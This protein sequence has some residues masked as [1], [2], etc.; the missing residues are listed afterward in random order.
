[1]AEEKKAGPRDLLTRIREVAKKETGIDLP[2]SLAEDLRSKL[3][4]LRLAPQDATKVVREVARRFQKAEVDA[5][6]S[7]GIIAAQSI[8]E[9]GTQMTLRTF[10]YAGVA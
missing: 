3:Q 1:M 5:H 8:G 10:H 7:V 2:P 6:E 4:G 9:P